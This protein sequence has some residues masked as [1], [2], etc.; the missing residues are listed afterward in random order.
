MCAHLWPDHSEEESRA[1][2]RRHLSEL[3]NALAP[4]GE[5]LL[6][7][8][9]SIRW[10]D[11]SSAFVDVLEFEKLAAQSDRLDDAL[12]LYRADLMPTHYE[13]WLFA[14]RERLRAKAL[15]IAHTRAH[16]ALAQRDYPHALA[17]AERALELSEWREDSLRLLMTAMYAMGN[18]PGA[19]AAFDRFSNTLATEMHVEPMAETLALRDTILAGDALPESRPTVSPPLDAADDTPFIGRDEDMQALRLAWDRAARGSGNTIFVSGEAGIGKTRL[20]RELARHVESRAGTILW[21][22]ASPDATTPYQPIIDI[23][24]SGMGLLSPRDADD[25]WFAIVA[26]AVP[27]FARLHTRTSVPSVEQPNAAPRLR[28]AFARVVEAIVG[29]TPALIVIEDLHWSDSDTIEAIAHLARRVRAS[30]TLLIVTHRSEESP[31]THPLRHL[32]RRL[33]AENRARVHALARLD[34]AAMI[35]TFGNDIAI[36]SEGNPLFA[37]QILQHRN[38]HGSL[39]LAQA[40]MDAIVSERLAH[41][42]PDARAVLDIAALIDESFTV[43]E[44]AEIASRAEAE[45]VGTLDLLLE[46]RFLRWTVSPGMALTFSHQLLRDVVI[47]RLPSMSRTLVHRRIASVLDATRSGDPSAAAIV[48][49]HYELGGVAQR[50]Y[51]LYL[52]RAQHALALYAHAS[53][54]DLAHHALRLASNDAQ[55]FSALRIALG[56]HTFTNEITES[57]T[58]DMAAFEA[59]AER[60]NEHEAR[61]EALLARADYLSQAV[62]PEKLRET[63]KGIL[64]RAHHSKRADWLAKAYDR[65]GTAAHF[66]GNVRE[67]IDAYTQSLRYLPSDSVEALRARAYRAS[68]HMRAGEMER[69]REEFERVDALARDIDDP[70][71]QARLGIALQTWAVVSEDPAISRAAGER[72]VAVGERAGAINALAVGRSML[73]HDAYLTGDVQRGRDMA[74]DLSAFLDAHEMRLISIAI[75]INMGWCERTFGNIQNAIEAWESALREAERI[76]R[77]GSTTAALVNLAEAHYL[78]GEFETSRER[79]QRA[80]DLSVA[81]GEE[82]FLS[83]S[84]MV[85]GAARAALGDVDA[86]LSMMTQALERRREGIS[87][88]VF[89]E[90]LCLLLETYARA[91]RL[92]EATAYASELRALYTAQRDHMRQ[93]TRICMALALAAEAADDHVAA[94]RYAFEGITL[95]AKHLSQIPDEETRA[96]VVALPYNRQLQERD[97][98]RASSS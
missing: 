6:A 34:P 63:I 2:L 19:L 38:E 31:L 69:G 37:Q 46:A 53:A 40:R 45:V 35:S 55:Q 44:V 95:L 58:R 54:I 26:E 15:L 73:M 94:K 72:L 5:Q 27:E 42:Q 60:L 11:E 66:L 57:Y 13:D 79:A 52:E 4:Y 86:S 97:P 68:M 22:H 87:S 25:L 56:A 41:L 90:G 49:H 77:N 48:A 8:R 80:H 12:A 76:G 61:F 20:V 71:L 23:I 96:N 16:A 67:A 70:L 64:V 18:R 47:A 50:A 3:N 28:E 30:K 9:Q 82:R 10:N 91:N 21:G 89:A 88:S 75:Q 14:P 39:P 24:K 33:V 29:D 17:C 85:L 84:L 59:T 32:R 36:A 98:G 74:R 93:P 92:S 1:N 83:E 78:R 62:D 7:D 81:T 51:E 43:E 65:A